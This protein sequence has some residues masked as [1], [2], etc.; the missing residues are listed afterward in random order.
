[1]DVASGKFNSVVVDT[2]IV[3]VTLVAAAT[4]EITD[5]IKAT[6]QNNYNTLNGK[7]QTNTNN[8]SN[9]TQRADSITSTV[10]QHTTTINNLTG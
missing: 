9:L 10:S 6:V 5:E 7:I 4:F 8:I 2:R 1:M 3:P